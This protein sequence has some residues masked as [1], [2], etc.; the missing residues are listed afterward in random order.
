MTKKD[1]P[2]DNL[3]NKQVT[4]YLD[5]EIR[6]W[7]NDKAEAESKVRGEPVSVS[8]VLRKILRELKNSS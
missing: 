4:V 3:R 6:E 2:K 5:D 1:N 8:E 7:L